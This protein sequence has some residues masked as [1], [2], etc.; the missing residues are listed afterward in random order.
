MS[1]VQV[2]IASGLVSSA[3][4]LSLFV[5]R[6][7]RFDKQDVSAVLAGFLAGAALPTSPVLFYYG[8]FP[9]P[10]TPPGMG[11]YVALAGIVVFLESTMGLWRL[12]KRAFARKKRR[13]PLSRSVAAIADAT[14]GAP[15]EADGG[16]PRQ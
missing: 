10:A 14:S 2:Q 9:N 5:T 11:I 4:L 13:G 15:G 12:A 16:P 6:Q 3:V 7:R 1:L 8:F